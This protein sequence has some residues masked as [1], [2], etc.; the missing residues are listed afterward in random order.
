M[1]AASLCPP[2]RI[3]EYSGYTV[4]Q[5]YPSDREPA[6][7]V[8]KQCLEAYGLRFEPEGADQDAIDIEHH[9]Q[10][11][12]RGEFWVVADGSGQLVGTAAYYELPG[13]SCDDNNDGFGGKSIVEIR[14]MY[15]LP[16][17]RGKKLGRVLLEVCAG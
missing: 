3:L 2:P 9:Y 10:R 13:C 12:E 7:A 1:A 14:K 8:V 16:E 15:L 11:G 5:W 17:A 4:R 6:A